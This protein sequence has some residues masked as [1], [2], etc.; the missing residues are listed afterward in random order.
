MVRILPIS[1][2]VVGVILAVAGAIVLWGVLPNVI[3]NKV[4]DVSN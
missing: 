1:I 4:A 3:R 2:A